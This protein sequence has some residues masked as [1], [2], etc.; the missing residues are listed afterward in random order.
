MNRFF[1]NLSHQLR[2]LLPVQLINSVKNL[3]FYR[4][5]TDLRLK[6]HTSLSQAGQDYWVIHEAFARKKKGYFIE[7]GSANGIDI[8][9]TYLLEKR[10]EWSGICVEANPDLFEQLKINRSSTCLNL[11]LDGTEGEVD[12]ILNDIH[13]GIVDIDADNKKSKDFSDLRIKRLKTTT[14]AHV[15]Q[16]YNAPNI[17]DYLSIDV[18]GAETRILQNF[19]FDQY[20]F[21]CITIERPSIFLNSLLVDSGYI[22]V[23]VIPGLDSFYI[24]KSFQKNYVKNQNQLFEKLRS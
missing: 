15:L 7:I 14:L 11:C 8:N 4:T 3:A 10:Y 9:N 19:P 1:D 24:H 12:F 6:N 18:E 23:K 22:L 16:E 20:I 21:C 5:L 2:R 13:G 17:I